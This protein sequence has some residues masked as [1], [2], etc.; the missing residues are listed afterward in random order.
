MTTWVVV[1]MMKIKIRI[2]MMVMIE[3]ED[4]LNALIR[5]RKGA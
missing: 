4:E 5:P 1:S 2:Y 3:K